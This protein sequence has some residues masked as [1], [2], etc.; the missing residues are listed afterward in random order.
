MI[1]VVQNIDSGSVSF[2]N[3][4]NSQRKSQM[5]LIVFLGVSKTDT[6]RDV[7]K[8]SNKLL[9]LR[10]FPDS[11]Q[12]M[13]LDIKSVGGEILLISQFTLLGNLK[14]NNRP[15]FTNAAEKELASNLYEQFADKL[16]EA[17]VRVT[18]GYFGEH[19]KIQVDLNGPVTIILDSEKL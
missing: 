19:M 12:K 10:V 18:K 5:G 1:A 17:G 4:S 16:T 8:V 11:D 14:G 13:N 9:K 15:D 2:K 3:D 7:E 6:E